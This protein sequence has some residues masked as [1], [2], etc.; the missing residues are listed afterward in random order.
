MSDRATEFPVTPMPTTANEFIEQ[1]LS[2]R[3]AALGVAFDS[4]PLCIFG[5]LFS[6]VDDLIR[7]VIEDMQQQDGS[8]NRLAVILTTDGGYIEPVQRIVDTIRHHYDYVSFIIPNYAFSAGTILVMSGNEIYMI[9]S[10]KFCKSLHGE[11]GVHTAVSATS[12]GAWSRC[13]CRSSPISR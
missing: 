9:K 4:D 3:L 1:Q 6:G 2:E 10:S 7:T 12:L 5:V 11:V 13:H 8:H